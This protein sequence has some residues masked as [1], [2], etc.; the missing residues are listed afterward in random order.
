MRRPLLPPPQLPLPIQKAVPPVAAHRDA[1][2]RILA[3]MLL[4]AVG[5]VPAQKVTNHEAR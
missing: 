3:E 5:P 1:A 2:L 4:A